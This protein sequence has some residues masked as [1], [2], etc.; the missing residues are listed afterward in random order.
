MASDHLRR[1]HTR[2]TDAECPRCREK[3]HC[4][5]RDP[6]RSCVRCRLTEVE[7][8]TGREIEPRPDGRRK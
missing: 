7:I 8:R 2:G 3:C 6:G 4:E 1:P 5:Y